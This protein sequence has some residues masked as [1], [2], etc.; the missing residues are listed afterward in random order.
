MA[1]KIKLQ[2]SSE[3]DQKK[4]KSPAN[5]SSRRIV[6]MLVRMLNGEAFDVHK[7][8]TEMIYNAQRDK[9]G[10]IIKTP[11][12]RTFQRD[13][14]IIEN[15]LEEFDSDYKLTK[16]VKGHLLTGNS[17]D[18]VDLLIAIAH[19]LLAS[20]A[21][22]TDETTEILDELTSRL[23]AIDKSIF[24]QN[25]AID[26]SS[27]APLKT[28]SNV[29]TNLKIL[30]QAINDEKSITFH[31]S[32]SSTEIKDENDVGKVCQGQ[33]MTIYFE[34]FYFYVAMKM[35]GKDELATFRLDRI[36]QIDDASKKG[37]S[38][39]FRDNFKL[40]DHRQNV[41]LLP[42]GDL[43][44]FTFECRI[45][46]QI[47]VDHFPQSSVK[48]GPNGYPIVSARAKSEGALLWLQSQG[49]NVKV[50][51]PQRFVNRIKENLTDAANQ[52]QD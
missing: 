4:P 19:I 15:V 5:L 27:Y 14:T 52:Y 9:Q 3:D 26:R 6:E 28:N 33:P 44:S 17:S 39:K 48:A 22:T 10:N 7:W 12:S 37:S 18:H 35:D 43:E 46:P 47:A 1:E 51:S 2:K 42:F 20:R 13:I 25:V 50:L 21:F 45:D 8:Q 24:N 41:Y 40:L 16:S 32:K 11:S 36:K 38:R 49:P 30:N 23:S 29:F 31:Y 34:M